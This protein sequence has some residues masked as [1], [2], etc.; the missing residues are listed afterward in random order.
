[1]I[2]G[3]VEFFLIGLGVAGF[4]AVYLVNHLKSPESEK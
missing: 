3:P 2:I 1:M 4:I